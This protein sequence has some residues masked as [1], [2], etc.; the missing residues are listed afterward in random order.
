[1]KFHY[2]AIEG[3]IGVGKTSL[4]ERLAERYEADS[5]LEEWGQN[6]FLQPFYD[7]KAGAAFQV[8]VF[9]LLSR[10]RQQQA[11]TQRNLFAQ[12]TVSDYVFEKSR[13]FAYL[14][15]EDNELQIF[16]KLYGLLSESVPRPDL[17]VYLQAPT[18][19]LLK[20][21]RSRKR[22]E[23]VRLSEEYLAEV[24]R[25]YNHYFFHYAQTPLLVVNTS[26]VDFVKRPEDVDDLMR[27][28]RGMG[29][30]TQYYAPMLRD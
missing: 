8:E 29:R 6:P 11:L 13:L 18:E 16:D 22:P 25:A 2:I 21:I 15:L 17:V 14:N 27:Q 19:V 12:H 26:E 5:V 1:M 30:G 10:Y 7:G 20:R 4:V 28:I 3:P 23:E 24:N 9:Y